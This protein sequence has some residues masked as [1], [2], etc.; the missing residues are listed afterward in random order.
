MAMIWQ[1]HFLCREYKDN[2]VLP[3]ALSFEVCFL[4]IIDSVE[5]FL[6]DSQLVVGNDINV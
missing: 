6:S 4:I 2:S 5:K 3:V 1:Y